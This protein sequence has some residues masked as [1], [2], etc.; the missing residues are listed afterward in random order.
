MPAKNRGLGLAT[1]GIIGLLGVPTF[2]IDFYNTQDLSNRM[3]GAGFRWTL[4]L[5][6][7][8]LHALDWIRRWTPPQAVVQVEPFVRDPGTWAYVPAFAER[9]MA[10]GIPISMVPVETYTD[11][12]RRVQWMFQS[13]DPVDISERASRLHIDYLFIGAPERNAYP[14][15]EGALAAR[16]DLFRLVF[17]EKHISI[18]YVE[19]HR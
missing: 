16:P 1:I 6:P 9:R 5:A 14:G 12:S 2:A 3:E 10:A 17:T 18:F 4:V 15:F 13:I 19:R 7:E 8:E 11:A